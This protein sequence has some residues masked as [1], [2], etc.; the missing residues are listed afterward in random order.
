M[1]SQRD[2][3][4]TDGDDKPRHSNPE[5]EAALRQLLAALDGVPSTQGTVIFVTN[6]PDLLDPAIRRLVTARTQLPPVLSLNEPPRDSMPDNAE[7]SARTA[8][9]SQQ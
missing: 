4:L 6:R 8:D 7:K 5:R 2:F 1:T 9:G 3:P